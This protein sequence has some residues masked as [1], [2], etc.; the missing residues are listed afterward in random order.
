[1]GGF[2]TGAP[3][4]T[5]AGTIQVEANGGSG[6]LARSWNALMITAGGKVNL[7]DAINH[8][9]RTVLIAG[10]L[11][12]AGTLDLSGNDL[13][14]RKGNLSDIT[15]QLANGF[16]HGSGYWNGQGIVSGIAANDSSF[17][18]ALG[19]IQR[20]ADGLF[21]GQF[22]AANDVLVKYTWYGDADLSGK[23]DG[24]DYS[25]IDHGFNNSA[26]GWQNGDFNYDGKIDG[27]DYSLIDNAFNLQGS[28]GLASPMNLVASHTVE[29]AQP[30]D[31]AAI[32][33]PAD[34]LIL[35]MV[36]LMSQRGR[37]RA[38]ISPLI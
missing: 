5:A 30:S 27:S 15:N 24:T 36:G 13:I 23:V 4:V 8:S 34:I 35:G 37:R 26:T 1:V 3:N 16:N 9:D 22:V 12:N 6:I 33:E 21:D 28:N 38:A 10:A 19:V 20:A 31:T 2:L 18:T 32:P 11:S 14:V 29:F 7:S 17:L 25:L